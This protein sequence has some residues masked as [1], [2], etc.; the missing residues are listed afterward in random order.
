M[1]KYI[2][3]GG[4][5]VVKDLH[6]PAFKALGKDNSCLVYEP[7][8]I[9]A[10]KIKLLFPSVNVN[11]D[12]YN[13]FYNSGLNFN[14]LKFV[15]IALPNTLHK[16]ACLELL[17]NNLSV[18]CEKP[19]G[20][21]SDDC[22]LIKKVAKKQ[23]R[24]CAVAMVRRFLPAVNIL[25]EM[26]NAGQLGDIRKVSVSHGCNVKDWSW[27]S[28][29]VL[30]DDQGGVLVNFGVHYIDLILWLFGDIVP[31]DY[32]D[33]YNGGIETNCKLKGKIGVDIEFLLNLSW[34]H[35]LDNKIIVEGSKGRLHLD[36]DRVDS[37]IWFPSENNNSS[38]EIKP[39]LFFKSGNWKPTFESCFVEQI[40]N[41]ETA[42][43]NQITKDLVSADEAIRTQKV[44]DWAY[45]IRKKTRY[46]GKSIRPDFPS[47]NVVVT[48]G[49]GFVGSH[50]IKRLSEIGMLN[51]VVPVRNFGSGS[52]IAKYPVKMIKTDLLN[53]E[54]CRLAVK[55]SRFIFHLAYDSSGKS[56][57]NVTILGTRNILKAALLEN[58]ESVV[59]FSTAT[60][61]TAFKTPNINENTPLA[62]SLGKYGWDKAFMQKECLDFAKKNSTLKV[63]V[64]A[65][66]SVYGPGSYLFCELPYQL[67]K[68][69]LFSWYENGNGIVNYI[70]VDNLVDMALLSALSIS[71]SGNT[72][73]G[74]DGETD[75][76]SFLLP[77]IR[78][79]ENKISNITRADLVY[80]KKYGVTKT[81][82]FDVFKTLVL[83]K[84]VVEKVNNN[85]LLSL[86]GKKIKKLLFKNND[87]DKASEF[88]LLDPPRKLQT[89]IWIFDIYNDS[90]YRFNNLKTRS[91]LGWIPIVSLSEGI[92]KS[93]DWLD[94]KDY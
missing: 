22:N 15:L 45:S 43:S 84:D 51:I 49:T 4:G 72:F 48:G 32:F 36:L 73:I 17:E 81:T 9:D 18:L 94:S 20:L 67:A 10:K 31:Y 63:S 89:P 2:I 42:L 1:I 69:G 83:S 86:I 27:N 92:K 6:L 7:N 88:I 93:V 29:T 78:K 52:A 37:C 13:S 66:G 56:S 60:V 39:T 77:L 76:K 21:S 50:L 19:L 64:I 58:V 68:K 85:F 38:F 40:W 75:W 82:F 8:P 80:L 30:R 5:A 24:V 61:W 44:I 11:C 57:E 47:S 41:F 23:S 62:P 33:D 3:F 34:T 12:T 16:E 46:L 28:E 71:A 70:Y 54:S 65:P 74:V 26:L 55:G 53:L 79:F 87:V 59:V 91:Q 25:K 14:D 90:Q 35:R